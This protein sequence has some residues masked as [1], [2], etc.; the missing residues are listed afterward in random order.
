MTDSLVSFKLP[1]I[2]ENE[3]N[4]L[5]N[6]IVDN[7]ENFTKSYSKNSTILVNNIIYSTGSVE[8]YQCLD[9]KTN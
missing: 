3:Y 4:P 6:W 5:K 7:Q 9:T 2:F 1:K 8:I